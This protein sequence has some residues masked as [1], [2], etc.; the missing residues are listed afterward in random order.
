MPNGDDRQFG[1]EQQSGDKFLAKEARGQTGHAQRNQLWIHVSKTHSG[2]ELDG[3]L[4]ITERRDH[5]A[6][7]SRI[8]R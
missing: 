4:R 3:S 6:D 1:Q 2:I 7:L 5:E 8:Q